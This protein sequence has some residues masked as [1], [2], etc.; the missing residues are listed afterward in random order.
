MFDFIRTV[1]VGVLYFAIVFA[2]GFVL[3]TLRVLFIVPL[4]GIRV[5]ELIE[6]PFMLLISYAAARWLIDRFAIPYTI[7]V[8]A[9][10]GAIALG[11]LL[12]AEFGF[13]LWLQHMTIGEYF[14]SRDPISG[15]AYLISLLV[16][17]LF[18]LL[19]RGSND[20]SS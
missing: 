20:V 15:T 18:P 17:G 4:V 8:R 14:S 2:A 1:R 6:T 9:A 16:F 11:L 12:L 10:V 19:V 7:A 5:A 13:V 3:G